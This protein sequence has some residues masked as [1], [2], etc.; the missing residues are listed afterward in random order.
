M[1]EKAWATSSVTDQHSFGWVLSMWNQ[2]E[3]KPPCCPQC[4]GDMVLARIFPRFSPHPELRTFQ[5]IDCG[6]MVTIEIEES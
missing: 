6:Q 4:S 2:D 1:G 3:P 5:C